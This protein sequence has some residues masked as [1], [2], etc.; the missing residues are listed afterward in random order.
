MCIGPY[1]V[2]STPT[3]NICL[4]SKFE[5]WNELANFV[6]KFPP[7][8]RIWK[9]NWQVDNKLGNRALKSNMKSTIMRHRIKRLI[10]FVFPG[11]FY[12][13]PGVGSVRDVVKV[14]LIIIPFVPSMGSR[15]PSTPST[16]FCR[17]LYPDPQLYHHRFTQSIHR[18]FGCPLFLVHDSLRSVAHLINQFSPILFT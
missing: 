14:R 8:F 15:V 12:R 7:N 13:I 18:F 3:M 17:Q 11:F 2:I 16:L 1:T 9:R 4:Q 5:L 6:A 10:I